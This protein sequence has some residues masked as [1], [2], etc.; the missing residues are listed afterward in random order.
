L[1][2]EQVDTEAEEREWFWIQRRRSA[3]GFGYRGG[4]VRVVLDTEAEE[5]EWFWIQKDGKHN[6]YILR[7]YRKNVY[8]LRWYRKIITK[9]K[10]TM[11]GFWTLNKSA[12]IAPHSGF[13]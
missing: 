3:S 13:A 2:K 1:D 12:G 6:V 7:W 9:K 4:G 11:A 8:I 5:R 10:R